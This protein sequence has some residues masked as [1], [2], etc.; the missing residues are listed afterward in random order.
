M[1]DVFQRLT[2]LDAEA[3]LLYKFNDMA[4]E[5]FEQWLGRLEAR[6]R[7]DDLHPAL[8]SHLGKMRKTMPAL[9]LLLTLADA[10]ESPIDL[11]H[12]EMAEAWCEYLESHARRVY[13]CVVTPRMKAAADL[14]AKLKKGDVGENGTVTRRDIYRCQWT[15]LDDPDKV[16]DALEILRDVGWVRP[17]PSEPTPFGGRPADRWLI[18]P[19]IRGKDKCFENAQDTT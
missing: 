8:V 6:I 4:Q 15:G 16:S 19:K 11:A 7:R 14:A 13:A 1:V 9:C 2:K 12:A 10:Q 18:N 5:F 3:P 17:S